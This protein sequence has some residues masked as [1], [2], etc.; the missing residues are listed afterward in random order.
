V[1]VTHYNE[2]GWGD[3]GDGGIIKKNQ[4]SSQTINKRKPPSSHHHHHHHN[5]CKNLVEEIPPLLFERV[6]LDEDE[7]EKCINSGMS[8]EEGV[9]R[10]VQCRVARVSSCRARD[11]I[12]YRVINQSI[13]K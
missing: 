5:P 6:H 3:D 1:A 11:E 9:A 10:V 2:E 13:N 8:L 12:K 7:R 4:S